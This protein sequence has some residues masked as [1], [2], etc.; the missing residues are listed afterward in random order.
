MVGLYG[1]VGIG[2]LVNGIRVGLLRMLGLL[3]GKINL[4][5]VATLVT[6]SYL[7]SYKIFIWQKVNQLELD[8]T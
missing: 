2:T 3:R 4:I 5:N 1:G 8:L 7:C 6:L